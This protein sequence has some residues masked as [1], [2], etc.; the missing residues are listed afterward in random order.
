MTLHVLPISPNEK[1]ETSPK[2]GSLL[3]LSGAETAGADV[4]IA[5]R[6]IDDGMD[7][8]HVGIATL[9]GDVVGVT[10]LGT[11]LL[12][13]AANLTSGGGHTRTLPYS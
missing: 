8:L 9:G 7:A 6:S 1:R 5:A 13:L 12:T 4:D 10:H 3:D 11:I 2:S